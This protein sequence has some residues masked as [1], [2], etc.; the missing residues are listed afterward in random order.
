MAEFGDIMIESFNIYRSMYIIHLYMRV[1]PV[2]D[3]IKLTLL[4]IEI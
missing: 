1:V 4:Y 3:W 2:L